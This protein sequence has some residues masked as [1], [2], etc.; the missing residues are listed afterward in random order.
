[1]A[2]IPAHMRLQDDFVVIHRARRR[3]TGLLVAV[4]ATIGMSAAVL[5][6]L[7]GLIH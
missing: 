5:V 3:P 6:L 2:N 4:G 1:M 7:A